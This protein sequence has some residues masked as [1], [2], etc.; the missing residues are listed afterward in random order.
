MQV[1]LGLRW[2]FTL[3]LLTAA[4]WGLAQTAG[5][6]T[7]SL[8]GTWDVEDSV[9]ADVLPA[10]YTHTVPVPGLA[11][12]AVPAFVDVDQF[13]SRELLSNLVSKNMYPQAEYEKLGSLKGFSRQQR[14]Y[15]WYRKTFTGPA[16]RT[17]AMLKINKA[18]FGA[19]VYLNGVRIGEHD[20]CFT[21][22]WFDVTK[23]LHWGGTNELVV[24]IGAHPNML[25][26]NVSGGTDFE[27]N[28]WTPG[29]YDDVALFA[30]DDPVIT[31]VQ[32]APQLATGRIL[33]RTELHNAS[34]HAVTT[35][36]QQQVT[37]RVSH[38]PVS[39]LVT[40][41]VNV[42]AGAT[43]TVDQRVP[44]TSPHLWSPEDP[45][46]YSVRTTTS[47]DSMDTRFGMREFRFDTATR[48]AY[49]NGKPYFLRGS[50]ITLHRF[51]E[52]PEVGTLP[53]D[54]AWL[55]KLLVTIP[56]GMH[57][58]AF[59]FCIGP[60]PDR[61]LEIADENGLL[62][63]NEYFVWVGNKRENYKQPYDADEMIGE[64]R[65]WMRDN[66]NH[67][68]VAIWDATN[69]SWL[70]GFSERVIPAVRN[71]DLSHR[72]WEDSYN[73]PAGGDDPVEDHQ[74]LFQRLSLLTDAQLAARASFQSVDLE[75][76]L[77]PT[78]SGSTYKSGHANILNE[79]GW[80]WL[81]RDG[82]PTLLT[83]FLYSRLLG[84]RNTT[85]NRFKLQ[86][87]LLGGETEFWRAT[88]HYAGILHFV[89]LTSSD[90]KAF[91]ADHFTD[92]KTLQLQPDFQRSMEQAFNP[93]G[94][95]LN[96]WQPKIPAGHSRDYTVEMVNDED[97]VRSGILRV[98]FKD[99]A[100]R[101]AAAQQRSFALTPF[102]AE[103]YTVTLQAPAGSGEY[104]VEAIATATDAAGHPTVSRRDVT[105]EPA[106]ATTPH[107]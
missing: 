34:T 40:T 20:P 2:T 81:N 22:A 24:R 67:P 18:Q 70:P 27:K 16:Q 60:V 4:S 96:F 59:R 19:V 99:A 58:N 78:P 105:L 41:S 32:V 48:R 45:F 8:N 107:P 9:A 51:F 15:F 102:G 7:V 55:H 5:R 82:T 65:E 83:P 35:T 30:M 93:L 62:I 95:Y 3:L 66:W 79:Y 94:V 10:R 103:S 53:W 84:D 61:W 42:A 12:S 89:Y 85:E 74:Y 17:V 25:P 64:Y 13:Q 47:G 21:A 29:I 49:L 46:L 75:Q 98:V 71:L 100:G 68:S 76:M 11:H 43:I 90:P 97:R 80:V 50:N 33:V 77:G 14:N 86:A 38:A 52:D 56:K 101:E 44:L 72:P 23:T 57:W 37:Q 63:Q 104:S 92:V 87:Y 28:R 1:R 31:N 6:S 91:T 73:A 26:A 39:T 54:E 69:E 36:V 106:S 88:R